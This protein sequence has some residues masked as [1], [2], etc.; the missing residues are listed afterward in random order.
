MLNKHDSHIANFV[1]GETDSELIETTAVLFFEREK[2]A[3]FL[4]GLKWDELEQVVDR[5]RRMTNYRSL[6]GLPIVR[7][8]QHDQLFDLRQ[9]PLVHVWG[10]DSRAD[11]ARADALYHGIPDSFRH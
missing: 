2:V 4:R 5:V 7:D 10:F 3:N 1:C 8:A 9:R 6:N 11:F